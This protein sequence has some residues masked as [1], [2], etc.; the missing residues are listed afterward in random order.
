[1]RRRYS[2]RSIN[3]GLTFFLVRKKDRCWNLPSANLD[4]RKEIR[5]D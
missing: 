2:Q 3:V 1:M 4:K 5:K